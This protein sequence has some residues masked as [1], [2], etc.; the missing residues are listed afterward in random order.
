[1]CIRDR[2]DAVLLPSAW[3]KVSGADLQSCL[4]HLGEK[5]RGAG[6]ELIECRDQEFYRV[7]LSQS[8]I[9]FDRSRYRY[10]CGADDVQGRDGWLQ[11]CFEAVDTPF[12]LS[13]IHI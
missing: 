3:A 6:I 2:G 11:L 8:L 13:L 9:F 5:L 10:R 1:M 7:P 4:N 12:G